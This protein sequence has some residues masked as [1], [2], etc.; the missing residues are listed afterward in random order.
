MQ[1][2]FPGFTLKPGSDPL[3][4]YYLSWR[5]KNTRLTAHNTFK[6]CLILLIGI[7]FDNEYPV[8]KKIWIVT[9]VEDGFYRKGKTVKGE[10]PQS[11]K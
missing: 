5:P 7:I 1:L 9:F 2:V 11:V 3:K 10:A 6:M 4:N 8:N